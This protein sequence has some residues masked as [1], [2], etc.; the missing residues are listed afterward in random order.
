MTRPRKHNPPLEEIPLVV[1]RF[2]AQLLARSP[3]VTPETV[4]N[5]LAYVYHYH[6]EIIVMNA[7]QFPLDIPTRYDFVVSTC[8][9]RVCGKCSCV[10]E[11]PRRMI[12]FENATRLAGWSEPLLPSPFSYNKAHDSTG[13]GVHE[14]SKIL[15]YSPGCLNQYL[16]GGSLYYQQVLY[17]FPAI[18]TLTQEESNGHKDLLAP[19]PASTTET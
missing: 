11:A 19:Q 15:T 3:A 1:T 5:A 9:W 14:T 6:I 4:E 2:Q 8:A 7:V 10:V 16:R 13:T 12:D 18:Y 17:I